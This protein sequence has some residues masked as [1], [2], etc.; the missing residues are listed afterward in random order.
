MTSSVPQNCACV[1]TCAR[2]C[3]RIFIIEYFIRPSEL[4]ARV[5][6]YLV[7][8][9]GHVISIHTHT[10]K[11]FF[12]EKIPL[13]GKVLL[14]PRCVTSQSVTCTQ[15]REGERDGCAHNNDVNKPASSFSLCVR[16]REGHRQ[17]GRQQT[18]FGCCSFVYEDR[19]L[20]YCC[21]CTAVSPWQGSY[22]ANQ[23]PIH[24]FPP[25]SLS[26]THA[27]KPSSTKTYAHSW[28]VETE[29]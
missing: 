7:S 27:P 18:P 10:R 25:L 14:L 9:S 21:S 11:G 17:E 6:A 20:C 16:E 15:R 29:H 22:E 28:S 23:F 4:S 2:A 12:P 5:S 1:C 19:G 3:A 24:L 13:S 26:H 8:P